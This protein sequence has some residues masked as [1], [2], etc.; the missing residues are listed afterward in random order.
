MRN[1]DNDSDNNNNNFVIFGFIFHFSIELIEMTDEDR[2]VCPMTPGDR[3]DCFDASGRWLPATVVEIDP[4]D[5]HLLHVSCLF[6]SIYFCK[7]N[8]LGIYV[9]VKIRCISL[10]GQID[11]MNGSQSRTSRSVSRLSTITLSQLLD[12]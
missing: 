4:D 6:F 8:S 10:D 9:F 12:P 11:G 3:C 7:R 1:N 2:K 5:K